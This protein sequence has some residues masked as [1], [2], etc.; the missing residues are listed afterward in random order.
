MTKVKIDL[1]NYRSGGSQVF[2]GRDRGQKVREAAHL[3]EI[4]RDPGIEVDVIVP[5]DIF[6][7]NS[8]FFL[9]MFGPS[10]RAMGGDAFRRRFHFVGEDLKEIVESGI[11][12]AESTTS[13]I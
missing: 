5:D 10:I 2:A 9:G 4:D 6:S 13:P 7:I 11:R 8:S 1:D 3:D 12:E